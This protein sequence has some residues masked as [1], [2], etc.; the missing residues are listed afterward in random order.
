MAD[1][2]YLLFDIDGTVLDFEKAEKAAINALF[3]KYGFGVCT[4]EMLNRYSV[5]NRG[6][7]E[8]LERNEI[9]KPEVLVGRFRDFFKETGLP[10]EKAEEFNKDYQSAL[11]DTIAFCDN[12][13]ELLKKA[14]GKYTLAAVTNGTKDAQVKKLSR[15]GLDEIFD[16]V[17]IS[18]EIGIE[19]PNRSFFDKV[20][21][22][23]KIVDKSKALIIGDSLTSDI[24]GGNNAEIDT[25]WY[26]P[27]GKDADHNVKI[28]YEISDLH[29][30]EKIL[31]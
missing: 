27:K 8:A 23:M 28:N 14:K 3:T 29:E 12:A 18:E 15:S 1:Y 25:C 16:Y 10:V 17:F 2:R 30:L 20:F 5:I 19:K 13:Y 9:S 11:G 6:Y 4:E 24:K 7:W 31:A 26:N 22:D 21:D